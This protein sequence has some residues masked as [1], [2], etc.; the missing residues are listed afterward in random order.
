M[1]FIFT[2]LLSFFAI[3]V[4]FSQSTYVPLDAD[5]YH[6]IDRYHIKYSDSLPDVHTN[7]KPYE[8]DKVAK[9]A[10]IVLRQDSSFSYADQFNLQYLLQDNWNYVQSSNRVIVLDT[11]QKYYLNSPT[12]NAA[13]EDIYKSKKPILKY[14]Y[15]NRTDLFHVETEDFSLS[16]NPVIHFQAGKDTD[17]DG[18]RYV[19]T[20]GIQLEGSIDKKLGFY[21]FLA[22]NQARFPQFV[23]DRI[24]RDTIVPHEG[25]WKRFK[26]DGYDFFT[27]RGY[28]TY[29]ITKHIHLQFGHDKVFTGNG[30]RSLILS[31]YAPAY[32]FLKLN[33]QIWKFQY[34]NL[35]TEMNADFIGRDQIFPKKYLAY[36]HLSFNLKPN[37]NIGVFESV[38][39]SRGKGKFEL[40]YLNP[41]IFYRSIEQQIGSEDNSLLGLDF[42][43]NFL[44]RF[45][46]YG[47]VVI[48]E[49]LLDSVKAGNGWWGNKQAFQAGAKY[50]DAFGIRNLD[51]QGEFNYIRPYTYQHESKYT[52]YQHYQQPL[53][54]PMGANLYELIGIARYQPMGKLA[55]TGKAFYTVFGA[56]SSKVN[57]GGNVLKPYSPIPR[58]FGNTVAQGNKTQLIHLDLTVSYQFKPNMF[59]DLQQIIRRTDAQLNAFDTSSAYSSVSFRWNI[60]QRL[61][62]F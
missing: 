14:F 34:Q 12:N 27:A 26:T 57:W 28:I 46:V 32:F 38:V 24:R 29:G 59:I 40:Q 58:I 3:S 37:L 19:N 42:K 2:F 51:L 4:A 45:Q 16:V 22:D 50:I 9:L 48:D 31:D 11:T 54:H 10:E 17:S 23:N 44:K 53:A 49:F 30:Y 62:E 61:H 55:I 39:F 8:R 1:R 15:R 5:K 25:Y 43:W 47:Q 6:L 21:T 36:H 20:R 60:G 13:P 18:L 33:T 7:L 35:F 52:N 56:D 41:I